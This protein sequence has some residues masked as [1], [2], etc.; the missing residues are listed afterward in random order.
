MS[1]IPKELHVYVSKPTFDSYNTI[2]DEYI[3]WKD[4]M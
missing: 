2:K 1:K 4:T 3:K